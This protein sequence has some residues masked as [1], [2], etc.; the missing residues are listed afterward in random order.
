LDG[1]LAVS[2]FNAG[3]SPATFILSRAD[4]MGLTGDGA[5]MVLE[6]IVG[7]DAFPRAAGASFKTGDK[8]DF[9]SGDVEITLPGM[10]G[11]MLL[12]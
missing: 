5:T 8:L 1:K 11:A 9:R 10:S 6:T 3:S 12:N 2:L 7:P 4:L